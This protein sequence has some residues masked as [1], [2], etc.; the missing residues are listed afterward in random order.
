MPS[1]WHSLMECTHEVLNYNDEEISWE[2]QSEFTI[3]INYFH[4]K[5]ASWAATLIMLSK[6]HAVLH[7]MLKP[8]PHLSNSSSGLHYY[9]QYFPFPCNSQY[10]STW[11]QLLRSKF[12]FP[13]YISFDIRRDCYFEYQMHQ[14]FLLQ[15]YRFYIH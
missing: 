11:L 2:H 14:K 5:C 6:W 8:P 15:L 9:H 10:I 3:L 13:Q 12:S 4:S 7:R 1:W